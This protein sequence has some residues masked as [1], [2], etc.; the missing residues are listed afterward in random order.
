MKNQKILALISALG[1]YFITT[2]LSYAM[3]SSILK[4]DS[5][6]SPAI[7]TPTPAQESKF[8]VD[9]TA[10][11]TAE[12]LLN[13]QMYTEAEKEI[14]VKRRPLTVMIENSVDAR[15]QSGITKADIVYEAIA[16]GGI[17]R[18]L[19]VFYCGASAYDWVIGP[20]RS[21]RTYFLDFASEY[22]DFPLYAHVGGANTPGKADALGQIASYGWLKKGNDMNQFALG[23]PVYWRDENRMG[24]PVATEHTMYSSV[25]RLWGVAEK[26]KLTNVD[27]AGLPWDKNFIAWKFKDDIAVS[28][29]GNISPE[30]YFW[31]NQLKDDFKVKWQYDSALNSY[32][33]INGGNLHT[34]KDDDSQVAAKNVVI[35]FMKESRADDGYENNL[36][37][38]YGTKGSGK[39]LFFQDGKVIEGTWNKKDR[40][41]RMIFKDKAGK[42]LKFNRGQIWIEVVAV[43]KEIVY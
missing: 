28:E 10:P 7:G 42:E 22:G 20:V 33:R 1:L 17:T 24:R 43:N 15:P 5:M 14:W 37:M 34:D 8:K 40:K 35:V 23:F 30:F 39:T 26:R 29:R 31:E 41:D 21:A 38:I 6:K 25:D 18:F 3:F 19:T 27:S 9:T 11:Q 13:G 4:P 16:E 12:C 2:G 32:T 36:H